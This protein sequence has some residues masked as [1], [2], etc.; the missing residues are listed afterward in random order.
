MLA[1][2]Q[3][4]NTQ[5][6]Q[7]IDSFLLAFSLLLA[8]TLRFYSTQWFHL[9]KTIDPFGAYSW[10][11][12]VVMLF[13]PI[14]LDLQG[15]YNSPIDKKKRRSVLQIF[16]AML[17]LGVIVSACVI[18]LRLPLPNRS[19]PILFGLIAAVT[20]L[21]KERMIVHHV[22]ARARRGELREPVLLAGSPEDI[23]VLE[24]SLTAEQQL[25]MDVVV[26]IDIDRQ[27]VSDLIEAMHRHSV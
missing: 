1:R 24:Q 18:F 11:L 10:L 3:E 5:V 25:L 27:P 4:L 7:L 14:L 13:G 23:A 9:S 17:Y 2:K 19:I 12:I 8:H 21:I 6:Q 16:Q 26:R 20:L 15:F 22:Q